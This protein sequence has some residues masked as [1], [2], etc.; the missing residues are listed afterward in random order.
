MLVKIISPPLISSLDSPKIASAVTPASLIFKQ[1]I[2][3]FLIDAFV[4]SHSYRCSFVQ[5]KFILFPQAVDQLLES[6]KGTC[7][8][9]T[10]VGQNDEILQL[11]FLDRACLS[12]DSLRQKPEIA[13]SEDITTKICYRNEEL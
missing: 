5:K 13:Y 8:A 9:S 4:A 12:F 3:L 1:E 10:V 2:L 11:N 6:Q 7:K